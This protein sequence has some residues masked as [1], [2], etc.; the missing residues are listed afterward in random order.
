MMNETEG[1]NSERPFDLVSAEGRLART[2]RMLDEK[3]SLKPGQR[4]DIAERVLRYLDEHDITQATVAREVG[5]S[6]T[7]ISEVLRQ[8]YA[9]KTSDRQLVKIHNWLELAARRQNIVHSRAF[10]ETSVARE[11]LQVASLTAETLKMSVVF[12]PA[13]IGKTMTLRSIVGD[14][15]FGD[16]VLI[17]V[18][19]STI[20]PFA[21]CRSI[22]ECFEL[23]TSGTFDRV[24]RRLVKRLDGTKRMLMFDE[25]DLASYRALEMVRQLHDGT[26]CAILFAGKPAIY[27]HLGFRHVGGFSERL[28]Q[29]GARII[30]HRDLTERTRGDKP[31]PLFTLDDIRRLIRQS[32]LKLHVAPDAERWLQGRASTLGMGGIGK[33]KIY[34]YLAYKVAFVKGDDAITAEHLEDVTDLAAG[35]E[36]AERIAEVVAEASGMKRVV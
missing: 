34:L 8:R 12:G 17:T 7:T 30:I 18:T 33:A 32:D 20:R 1:S 4:K 36:D 19:D 35:H 29:M 26:G 15:R 10:V 9:G 31:Q 2:A 28:D 6:T 14:Q 13:H 22:C 23:S 21:L 27:E 24:F 5:I 16:P 3:Q 25:V 11:I